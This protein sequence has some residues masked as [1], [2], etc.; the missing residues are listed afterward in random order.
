MKV[1]YCSDLHL[2]FLQSESQ[3]P[4]LFTDAD[5]LVLAGDVCEARQIDK[6]LPFI[7][8]LCNFYDHVIYVAGNHEYY[9]GE[10]NKCNRVL[11]SLNIP[12][13]HFLQNEKLTIEG[14]VFAGC[15]LWSHITPIDSWFVQRGMNDYQLIKINDFA[16]HYRRL[17]PDDTV[18][19]HQKSVQWLKEQTD[20]DVVITHHL[21]SFSSVAERYKDSPYNCCY[22]SNLSE[23]MQGKQVWI[24]GHTHDP[25]DYVENGCRVL[26]NPCGYPNERFDGFDLRVFEIFPK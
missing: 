23:L 19:I 7:Q 26:C 11:S 6:Y 9:R 5:V 22:A 25:Y 14:V 16:D 3:Y 12:N 10:L 20:V 17:H 4:D 21:P 15:T 8:R 2:E 24:H 13:L 1:A 18:E